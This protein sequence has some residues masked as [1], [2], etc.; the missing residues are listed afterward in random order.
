MLERKRQKEPRRE[1]V[2]E[3]HSE[4]VYKTEKSIVQVNC[5]FSGKKACIDLTFGKCGRETQIKA[6]K[7]GF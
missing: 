1:K 6:V 4:G 3:E 5:S 7:I 2:R